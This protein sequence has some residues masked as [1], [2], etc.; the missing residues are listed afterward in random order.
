MC[1]NPSLATAFLAVGLLVIGLALSPAAFAEDGFAPVY[2]PTLHVQRTPGEIRIDGW[3][4][5]PGWQDAAVTDRFVE[6]QPGDQVKPPVETKAMMTYDDDHL[7]VAMVAR[8][9]PGQVRA[10]LCERDRT[11]GDDNLG[12]FIDTYGDAA[13]AYMFFVNAH[14]V[15]YD[16]MWSNGSGT[17]TKYDLVWEAAGQKTD[18]GFQ[19]EL[20]IPFASL[21]F[22]NQEKQEW[23]VEFFRYHEREV[24]YELTWAAYDRDEPCWPCQWGT[25]T[26]IENVSPGRGVE[27]IPAVVGFQSGELLTRGDTLDFHN[28]DVDGDISLSTKY[29]ISSNATVE[30][31]I[32]PDFS[33]VEA[34]ADQIDVNSTTALSFPEKRPFFQEGS[35]LFWSRFAVVD[36]RSINEPDIAA[37]FTY[38]KG[39]TSVAYLGAH[40]RS[41][42]IIIPFSEFSSPVIQAEESFSN[43]FR[44]R[45]TFGT[46][47][48]VGFLGTDRRLD[49]GGSGSTLGLDGVLRLTKNLQLSWQTTASHTAEPD[50]TTITSGHRYDEFLFDGDH[51]AAYDGESY[52]GHALLFDFDYDTRDFSMT[53]AYLEKSPTFRAD[54]G[55]ETLNDRQYGDLW[56]SGTVRFDD[57]PLKTI[58]P[59]FGGYRLWNTDGKPKEEMLEFN[60]SFNFRWAQAHQHSQY[61]TGSEDYADSLFD[62]LWGGHHCFTVTPNQY[63]S[64]GG[65]AN[66]GHKIARG[67][68]AVGS[69][70]LFTGWL[71]LQPS[72]C[73]LLENSFSHVKSVS[74]NTGRELFKTYLFRSKL[75]YHFN[76]Q[77]W[78][79][80]VVQYNDRYETWDLDPLLTYQ[81][82]PFTLFYVGTTYDYRTYRGLNSSGTGYVGDPDID[83]CYSHTKLR[84]R[85]FFM[86][87][88]YLFQI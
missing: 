59:S 32:N 71:D 42:L 45:Q 58:E 26:G 55:M 18:S 6:S 84:S 60:L 3:L 11:P 9:D 38:R 69:E 27:V 14:G 88:Q 66:Y 5:D 28:E 82:N 72:N 53:S 75:T 80:L 70:R 29:S 41:S 47:S 85:Q 37:K 83:Q 54:N 46:N 35:D 51:T 31:A 21:R 13:W 73:I 49:G 68:R 15:Q 78:L 43:I 77:I 1:G 48:R 67:D 25:V 40:D 76:R 30:V 7:F 61:W 65:S 74:V 52:W 22:P 16:A 79:R 81:I 33:Q 57:G 86:K 87:L 62:G 39:R 56:S 24:T 44:V 64:F 19:V 4:N 10:S 63:V 8:A 34:D 2:K 36:T 50:D 23:R 12:V 20:A 17:D